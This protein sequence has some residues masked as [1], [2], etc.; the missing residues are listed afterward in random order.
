MNQTQSIKQFGN[1]LLVFLPMLYFAWARCDAHVRILFII[2]VIS[3][4]ITDFLYDWV[5]TKSW[6]H[7]PYTGVLAGI[8]FCF[9]LTQ[10]A[11]Y[12][13]PVVAA[14]IWVGV[15]YILSSDEI[16]IPVFFTRMI[17]QIGLPELF[18]REQYLPSDRFYYGLRLPLIKVIFGNAGGFIGELCTLSI[19]IGFGFLVV[20]RSI[21]WVM[22]LSVMAG[23]FILFLFN[24]NGWPDFNHA[25]TGVCIGSFCFLALIGVS[26]FQTMNEQWTLTV[27]IF[28]G[29]ILGQML[30]YG[31]EVHITSYG[32]FLLVWFLFK[33]G[34]NLVN[35]WENALS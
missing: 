32:M 23:G 3:F 26:T 20:N 25:L 19:L 1:N 12:D 13:F 28:T 5:R 34:T 30:A 7:L 15:R 18:F 31:M 24:G 29:I 2:S 8:L 10:E 27:R 4:S 22:S 33:A 35:K 9:T 6:R 14:C 17:F 21:D 16:F 11:V